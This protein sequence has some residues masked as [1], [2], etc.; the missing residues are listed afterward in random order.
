MT[1][2]AGFARYPSEV[3]AAGFLPSRTTGQAPTNCIAI[4]AQPC[5][6]RTQ[7]KV[8]TLAANP[9]SA[10]KNTERPPQSTSGGM[11]SIASGLAV[12]VVSTCLCVGGA[13]SALNHQWPASSTNLNFS[14]IPNVRA[15]TAVGAAAKANHVHQRLLTASVGVQTR[16]A[17]TALGITKS[18]MAEILGIQRPHLYEWLADKV[19]RPEKGDRLR[20]L[21]KL[22]LDAGI[23]SRDPLRGH[24]LTEPLEPGSQPLVAMLKGGD[25]SSPA[26]SSALA[27]ARRLN[28]AIDEE[29]AERQARMRAAGHDSGSDD[30]RQAKLEETLTMMEWD[31]S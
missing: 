5:D 1:T 29:A 30:D 26:I 4:Q 25:L 8:I 24:L 18:Q 14:N 15:R 16:E 2:F 12:A 11:G 7:A 21:L 22:L 27:T 20:D 28:R 19:G 13:L 3:I 9:I 10:L 23:S 31:H 17:L 6:D